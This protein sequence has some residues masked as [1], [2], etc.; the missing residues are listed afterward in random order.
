L[1]E[2]LFPDALEIL[3]FYHLKETIFNFAKLYFKNDESKYCLWAKE[4]CDKMEDGKWHLV[5]EKASTIE[6]KL[7]LKTGKLTSYIENNKDNIDYLRYAKKGYKVDSG[8]IEGGNKTVLYSRLKQIGM[9]WNTANA[10]YLLTLCAKEESGKW[11]SDVVQA[12]YKYFNI[13]EIV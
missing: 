11:F 1:K 2:R 8:S 3:D 13:S 6:N 4:M 10:K 7:N 5:F 12:V 9:S